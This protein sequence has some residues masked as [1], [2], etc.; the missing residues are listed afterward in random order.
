MGASSAMSTVAAFLADTL[1]AERSIE[2]AVRFSE[3][4]ERLAADLDVATH[5]MW[6]V[7][8]ANATGD[9]ALAREAVALAGPTDY[10]DI[11][12]RALLAVGD[13]DGAAREYERKGNVAGVSR[14]AA[15]SL[16]SS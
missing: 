1:A 15:A 3:V 7:A 13:S 12:A 11:R 10:T 14:I 6:R 16:R 2:D 4:S 9:L 8:R 5:V